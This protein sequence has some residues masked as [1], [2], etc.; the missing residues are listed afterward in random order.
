LTKKAKPYK[1]KKKE[2]KRTSTNDAVLTGC[3][4]VEECK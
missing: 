2:K 1:K 4:Y 3:L